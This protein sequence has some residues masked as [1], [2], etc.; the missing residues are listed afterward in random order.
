MSPRPGRF[1]LHLPPSPTPTLV[2]QKSEMRTM[3]S[4]V[5]GRY[6]VGKNDEALPRRRR[7][8]IGHTLEGRHRAPPPTFLLTTIC[9]IHPTHLSSL[10]PTAHLPL[11][12]LRLSTS[13]KFQLHSAP[14]Q[15]AMSP[16]AES[17]STP[18]AKPASTVDAT[19][20]LWDATWTSTTRTSQKCAPPWW[21]ATRRCPACPHETPIPTQLKDT[22]H[23]TPNHRKWRNRIG[24]PI[25]HRAAFT[26]SSCPQPR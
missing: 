2:T 6:G 19:F 15:Q 22:F 9:L 10:L 13:S 5:V 12:P 16:E 7:P 14:T 3:P 20:V 4:L 24:I 25:C 18:C 23:I 21:S 1:L 26:T 11:P 17:P 8:L